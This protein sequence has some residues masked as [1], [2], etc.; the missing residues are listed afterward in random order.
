MHRYQD[1]KEKCF[2]QHRD[3]IEKH[4][5]KFHFLSSAS[6]RRG[7]PGFLQNREG[8]T[9]IQMVHFIDNHVF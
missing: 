4:A 7:K 1:C 5:L 9:Q 8:Q 3:A 6:D 2:L